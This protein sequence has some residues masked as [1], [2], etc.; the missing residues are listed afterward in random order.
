MH[1]DILHCSLACFISV[2]Q[3]P[4]ESLKQTEEIGITKNDALIYIPKAV[5]S[6]WTCTGPVLQNYNL[7]LFICGRKD[8]SSEAVDKTKQKNH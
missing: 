5:F 7:K 3:P 6:L 4:R 8:S 2:T 1:V